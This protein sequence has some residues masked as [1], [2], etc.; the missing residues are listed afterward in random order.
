ME[1]QI[2]YLEVLKKQIMEDAKKR[3]EEI[4]CQINSLQQQVKK[5]F[6]YYKKIKKSQFDDFFNYKRGHQEDDDI[7][8]FLRDIERD[9]E[10]EELEKL[11]NKKEFMLIFQELEMNEVDYNEIDE[12]TSDDK[13]NGLGE[14]LKNEIRNYEWIKKL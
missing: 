4:Q 3:C 2:N 5:D 10:E 8:Y 11:F 7:L 6:K 12:L 14:L 13:V 1:Q 9:L